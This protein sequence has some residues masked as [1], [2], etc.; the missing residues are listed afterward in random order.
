MEC[1]VI[2]RWA[3]YTCAEVSHPPFFVVRQKREAGTSLVYI[4]DCEVTGMLLSQKKKTRGI[5]CHTNSNPTSQTK[6]FF[7]I[8]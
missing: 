5:R 3:S 1:F 8:V 2:Y 7:F 6:R 4:D